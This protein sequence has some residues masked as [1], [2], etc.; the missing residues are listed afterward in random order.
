MAMHKTTMQGTAILPQKLP[1]R[2]RDLAFDQQN[3]AF[4]RWHPQGNQTGH[5]FNGLSITFPNGERHFV[6]S[7]RHYME[8]MQQEAPQLMEQ[9]R[10]FMGQESI[11]GREHERWNQAMAAAGYPVD[12][13]ERIVGKV[14]D[15][16]VYKL[17]PVVQLANT[18]AA[19]HLTAIGAGLML[20]NPKVLESVDPKAAAFWR[21]HA[22]EETEHKAVAYDVY[23]TVATKDLGPVG[24]YLVRVTTMLLASI[25]FNAT[26]TAFQLVLVAHDRK[27]TDLGGWWRFLKVQFLSPGFVWRLLIPYLRYYLPGFHPWQHDNHVLVEQWK[28][29]N[30]SPAST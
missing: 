15:G 17:P 18:V 10:G 30:E 20:S 27:L 13:L 5:L 26:G 3:I 8:R 25:L 2:R 23:R 24:A 14:L 12:A 16:F 1:I 11:H 22:I 7:V 19:E 21:W 4:D 9:I 28:A 6:H 29:A